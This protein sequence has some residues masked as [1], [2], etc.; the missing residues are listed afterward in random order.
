MSFSFH[1]AN[2]KKGFCTHKKETAIS[3]TKRNQFWLRFYFYKPRHERYTCPYMALDSD[4]P[5]GREAHRIDDMDDRLY[6]RDLAGRKE[7]RF[8][9]LTPHKEVMQRVWKDTEPKRKAIATFAAHPTF[10]KKFFIG[11]VIFAIVAAIIVLIT[12]FTGGNSVSNANIDLRVTGNSFAAGG[13]ELPLQIDVVN[14]N[15]TSLELADLFVEYDK[16]GDAT[17][18]AA[19]TRNLY[20]LKSIGAGKTVSKNI[21]VTLYGEEGGTK[22]VDL[23][24][25]Y[26]IQGSNAIFI[27]KS[28]FP[29]TISSA[30]VALSVDAPETVTPNQNL[31]YTVKVVSNAKTPVVGMLLKISY[32]SGFKFSSA[33]PSPTA[34]DNTWFLGDMAPGAERSV[35]INGTVYGQDGEDRAFNISVGAASAGDKSKIGL[36][37]NSRQQVVSLVKPFLA[38]NILINGSSEESVPVPS[39]GTVNVSVL[40]QNNMPTQVT[41]AEIRVSLAGNAFDPASVESTNGFYDSSTNT[42]VWNKTTSPALGSI[43]PSD[44]GTVDFSFKVVP[45]FSGSSSILSKPTI[46]FAVSIK[47]KQSAE[48]GS[49]AQLT[50]SETKK[51]VVSSDLGFSTQALYASGP[52]SNTGPVPP[53]AGEPTTYTVTWTVTNSANALAN[54]AASAI[55]PTYVDWVGTTTPASEKISYD[56]TTRTIR[57]NIG[58]VPPGAGS[59]AAARSVSFQVRITPSTSQVGSTPKLVL[60]TAVTARDTFT[61]ETLSTSRPAISTRLDNDPGAP[62]T[63]GIVGN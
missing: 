12:F 33:T 25:Q 34:L 42:I 39:G 49:V 21:F 36:V 27:K 59:S 28:S 11:A 30:P 48:G 35:E 51:A 57:W 26:R 61:G 15:A 23:T 47:G 55:L 32:P 8:D 40:W 50:A 53:Q 31:K 4:T 56:D 63:S 60:E 16:G 5:G 58:Q 44:R 1:C 24:L 52:F 17:S 29:V 3:S 22:S 38:A 19:R 10:F 41:D 18:G 46:S 6:R 2:R 13:E 43:E 14:K 45:L 54:G 62:S 9:T 20:S 37:Y 7:K